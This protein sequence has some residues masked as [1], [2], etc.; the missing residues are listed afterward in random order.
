M[1]FNMKPGG[2]FNIRLL[3][4]EIMVC[5]AITRLV[6]EKRST[7]IQNMSLAQAIRIALTELCEAAVTSGVVPAPDEYN[8]LEEIAQ[9]RRASASRQGM[10]AAVQIGQ[11]VLQAQLERV[12]SGGTAAFGKL[13][14]GEPPEP[15]DSGAV[16]AR[17]LRAEMAQPR[18]RDP[19]ALRY[20][21]LRFRSEQDPANMSAG[22]F[23][24]MKKLARAL[25]AQT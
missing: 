22:E 6:M 24:E 2:T 4:R 5:V 3:P 11:T 9:F 23:R 8:Y 20:D 7:E 16:E 15:Q 14:V 19:R 18:R 17:R 21:E 25:G 12:H 1:R 10:A 13:Q